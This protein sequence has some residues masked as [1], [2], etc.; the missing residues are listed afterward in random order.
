MRITKVKYDGAKVRI[1]YEQAREVGDPDEF[2]LNCA[3]RPV[4]EFEAALAA[5]ID[6]V[7]EICELPPEYAKGIKVRGVSISWTNDVMGACVTAL[8]TLQTA[9]SPLVINTPHLPSDQYSEGGEAPL[10]SEEFVDHVE[11]LMDRATDYINGTRAQQSLP[12]AS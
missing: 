5:L 2:S 4:P 3:D 6:D 9:N 12:L 8:R 7:L 10:M 11:T 1:E